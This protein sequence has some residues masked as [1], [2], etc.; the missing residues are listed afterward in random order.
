MTDFRLKIWRV[1]QTCIFELSWAAGLQITAQLTYPESLTALY[2]AWQTAYLNFYSHALRSR[3]Q[4]SGRITSSAIDWRA[5]LVQAEARFLSEFYFWLNSAELLGIR[6]QIAKAA[7]VQPL[8][9]T[10]DESSQAKPIDVCLTCEPLELARF[11]WEAW[12]IGTEFGTNRTIRIARTPANLRKTAS[13]RRSRSKLR[14]LAILGDDTGLDFQTDRQAM[15]SLAKLATIEFVGW[16]AGKDPHNL[17]EAIA[18]A[19]ADEQGW[20]ILF[21]AGHSNETAITGG[22]L[23]IAP[24]ISILV[25]EIAPQL[26]KARDRGLQFAIFNSCSGLSIANSLVDLGLSQVAIMREP[27][28]NR[29]AQE[30]LLRFLQHL[31]EYCDVHTAMLEACTFLKVDRNLTYPSAY[32]IPSLYRHP[33]AIPFQL[34]PQGLRHWL[35]PW[36][37]TQKQA[38]TLAALTALSLLPPIENLL[39]EA[40]VGTQAVYRHITRQIP[41]DQPSVLLVQVD[42]DSIRGLDARKINPIDRTYLAQV[43]DKAQTLKPQVMSID[44]LL[45]RPTTEDQ[46]LAKAVQSATQQGQWLLFSAQLKNNRR[47]VGVI[48]TI[49]NPNSTLQ[50]QIDLYLNYA[51]IPAAQQSCYETCPLG[52][53]TALTAQLQRSANPLN[54]TSQSTT[55]ARDRLLRQVAQT[56]DAK[57]Q[58]LLNYRLFPLTPIAENFGQLWL[59][60]ILDYSIPPNQV[61]QKLSAGTLLDGKALDG[62]APASDRPTIILIAAGGYEQ[63]GI[64]RMGEDNFPL[65]LAVRYWSNAQ[66]NPI[67]TG[68]EAHAYMIH[69]FLTGHRIIPI[70]ALWLMGLGAI[71]GAG[72][73]QL[74]KQRNRRR[75]RRVMGLSAITGLY[76]ISA[77]QLYISSGLLL[78][79]VL[80]TIVVWLYLV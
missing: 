63:A 1:E 8:A 58:S 18:A 73:Q 9:D 38:W 10:T 67:F 32:L 68:G 69:Q 55:N 11:P 4:G 35:K 46:P 40:R 31:S 33:E 60:P 57:L 62:K 76:G 17:K 71:G 43:I 42:E 74:M 28:H 45:D 51:E 50:G 15:Q 72:L 12:E 48:P 29:V 22:E 13:P 75:H 6:S 14:I 41:Q 64:S 56:D 47:E 5:Q 16:Q 24:G 77:L 19:I 52:Y 54:P 27:I 34:Q 26:I 59:R 39:L 66:T 7:I 2:Q 23:T 61:Y 53:L 3:V 78:P 80:P 25:Q 37:P 20:D 65:P 44:F 70:P 49:G 79:I 30:F 21:F 36:L